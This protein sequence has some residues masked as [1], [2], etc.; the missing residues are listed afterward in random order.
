MIKK[1]RIYILDTSAILSGKPM[2]ITDA[3]LV[4]TP[5]V[6]SELKPG[7]RDYQNFEF[8]KEKGLEI[9]VPSK[10]SSKKILDISKVTG[11]FPRLSKTDIQIA[12]LALDLSEDDNNDVMILTDD[13]SI[14]N[15]ANELKIKFETISQSGITKRFKWIYQCRGCGKKFKENINICPICGAE[16]R[17]TIYNKKSLR[18]K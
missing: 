15:V 7:G 8:M 1:S 16:T 12:A 13:Y 11:D 18:R 10:D 5:L 2:N 9:L 6:A 17:D 14:Q 3:K 4:T